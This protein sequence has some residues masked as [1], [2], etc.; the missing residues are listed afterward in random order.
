VV[1][2]MM[3]VEVTN[4]SLAQAQADAANRMNAVIG[5]LKSLGIAES[6]IKTVSYTVSPQ[7]D[8]PQNGGAPVLRGF[9]VSNLVSVKIKDVGR[10][11][12]IID[13]VIGEGATNIQGLSFALDNPQAAR[14]QARDQAMQDARRKAEQLATLA[15]VSVGRPV[16]ISESDTGGPTPVPLQ[17]AAPAAEA[18]APPPIQPGTTEIRTTVNV[19]YQIQ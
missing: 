6:D 13:A 14:D 16:S 2:L 12:E 3:G 9:Q 17:R 19:T 4:R 10:A 7:Y 11:G 1:N 8:Y 15:G 18:A 5:K